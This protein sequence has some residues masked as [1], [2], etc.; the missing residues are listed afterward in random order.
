VPHRLEVSGKT[1]EGLQ[2][3][4]HV[5]ADE[6]VKV[7]GWSAEKTVPRRIAQRPECC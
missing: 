5:G 1:S 4:A 7:T 2:V 6:A 3:L